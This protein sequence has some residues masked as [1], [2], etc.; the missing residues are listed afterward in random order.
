MDNI[1]ILGE[2]AA[3]TRSIKCLHHSY[4]TVFI[5]ASEIIERIPALPISSWHL[6]VNPQGD[7]ISP[8]YITLQRRIV[9]RPRFD[10]S[11]QCS[12]LRSRFQL[13]W[14]PFNACRSNSW[15]YHFSSSCA[16]AHRYFLY[17]RILGKLFRQQESCAP[18]WRIRVRKAYVLRVTR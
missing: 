7:I 8:S 9:R 15:F 4:Q 14:Y 6:C 5:L 16:I 10:A 17:F 3:T 18:A 12:L 2:H 1:P 13:R 11:F